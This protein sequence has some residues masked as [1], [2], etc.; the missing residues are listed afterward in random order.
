[1]LRVVLLAACLANVLAFLQRHANQA[2][3]STGADE[4]APSN[5]AP[6]SRSLM[7][8]TGPQKMTY[9]TTTWRADPW[10]PV[11]NNECRIAGDGDC[12]DGGPGSEYSIC[13]T[14]TDCNDC[15]GDALPTCVDP[16]WV[17]KPNHR[18]VG[19]WTRING[20]GQQRWLDK[21]Y[22]PHGC[23]WTRMD[24][25]G[26][27]NEGHEGT[28]GCF[29]DPQGYTYHYGAAQPCTSGHMWDNDVSRATAHQPPLL[30]ARPRLIHA[31][32]AAQDGR[33]CDAGCNSAESWTCPCMYGICP[34]GYEPN[35]GVVPQGWNYYGSRRR[36]PYPKGH[37]Y[38]YECAAATAPPAA[39]GPLPCEAASECVLLAR[40]SCPCK[41]NSCP[42][43]YY[44][45]GLVNNKPVC[46]YG[47]NPNAR[48][49][50]YDG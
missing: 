2:N 22:Y 10:K 35:K 20:V 47:S 41:L 36:Y 23:G 27:G 19:S 34:E 45:A 44:S 32:G 25:G 49:N 15:S 12:D 33:T 8:A 16:I 17:D 3:D 24:G 11:C 48:W 7:F 5:E 31:N 13:E 9:S 18:H 30:R 6:T 26:Q 40:L 1:M 46:K 39:L 14:G 4:R 28:E 50:E 42:V 43:G 29:T 21:C 37:Y 38:P